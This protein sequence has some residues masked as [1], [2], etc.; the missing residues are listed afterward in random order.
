[1]TLLGRFSLIVVLMVALPGVSS[2]QK[3]GL[4]TDLSMSACELVDV[5][6]FLQIHV[7]YTGPNTIGVRFAAPIPECWTG[8]VF[9]G[10]SLP[11][12]RV[13]VGTTQT[14]FAVV[15][16]PTLCAT[17]P[18]WFGDINVV[19]TGTSQPCCEMVTRATLEPPYYLR[20][21]DC[22]MQELEGLSSGQKL[23]VNPGD[24]CHCQIPLATESTTWGRVKSLYR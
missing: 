23:V 16:Y 1:M 11:P 4:Y 2:A 17:P 24:S 12:G 13:K 21:L 10:N 20:Y 5:P 22:N 8:A 7:F 18:I 14:D 6:G 19:S 9:V 15:L 3:V